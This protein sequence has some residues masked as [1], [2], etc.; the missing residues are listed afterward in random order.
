MAK[1]MEVGSYGK[2]HAEFNSV[3]EVFRAIKKLDWQPKRDKQ[4]DAR[5]RDGFHTFESLEEATDTF[6]H[7]PERIRKFIMNDTKLEMPSSP[8][9]DIEYDV[10]GDFIDMDR[11]MEGVPEVF[12]NVT[13]GNPRNVFCT[14]NVLTSF[15]HWT[16]P[17]YV[18]ARLSRVVRLIDWLEER[19]VRCQVVGSLDSAPAFIST[20]AKRFA[21]PVDLNELC[22]INHPDWLRRIMFL[23]KEQSK[24]WEH[25]Y[26][27]ALPYDRKM[28]DYKPRPED[29][30]YVY[31]GG[32]LP[33]T[34]ESMENQF[35]KIEADIT[36]LLAQ[37]M[38]FNE[39]PLAIGG[40]EGWY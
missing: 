40:R 19:N 11:Y 4:S 7:H 3:G 25:G 30:L 32:Y 18:L 14:I 27:S 35:D 15:V 26:G 24:T 8:G 28:Q 16:T 37:N 22:S 29:G 6:L 34:I 1:I 21:E 10:T 36:E 33:P 38:T 20:I 31:V 17:E 13:M 12:G 5:G 2:L 23:I 39:E 9:K